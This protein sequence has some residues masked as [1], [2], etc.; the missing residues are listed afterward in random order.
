MSKGAFAEA[1][2][3]AVLQ[4]IQGLQQFLIKYPPFDQ[5]EPTHLVYLIE[6]CQLH[7]YAAGDCIA[8]PADG[9]IEH[10]YIIKQGHVIGQRPA[11][12]GEGLETHLE[13]AVGECFPMA[14]MIGE[15]A[16]RTEYIADE[17][18][19]CLRFN[20]E[21]FTRLLAESDPF[22]D[23][24]MRG[25]S[26]LLQM[27]NQQVQLKAAET[28]GAQYSLDTRLGE[29]CGRSPVTCRSGI[30][31]REAVCTM[32]EHMIGGL[33]MVD[34]AFSPMGLFALRDLRR[35]IADGSGQL[36]TPLEELMHREPF[37]LP[38]TATAFDAA[39]AMTQRHIHHVLV[40]EDDKLTGVI[41]ERD[42]F[43]LQRVDLVHLARSI[44][45][46]RSIGELAALRK[47][48]SHLVDNMLAHGA[49]PAQLTHIISL[50]NDH[51]VCRVIELIIEQDGDPGVPFTWLVFG[52]EGRREQTL[53]TDQDN[54]ILFEAGSQTRPT[55]FARSC[56]PWPGAS[57]RHWTSAA[58]P[59]ARAT[60]WPATRSCACHARNGCA[61]SAA[62]SSRRP[63]TTC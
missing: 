26:S 18:T 46:A 2:R 37:C 52:S 17:D 20:R 44:S 21:A 35:V 24:A 33:V 40:V 7:F 50:L 32:Q 59:C 8:K 61:A 15:R 36:D 53:H 60:S 49:S 23:F 47:D 12:S 29:L 13:V 63:R 54:G 41:S 9:R 11:L 48:I 14:A 57:T 42:L 62:S 1:G 22:R 51:T 38:P 27:V 56:Y 4:N 43:S 34:E 3:T 45:S 25:V 19:F 5:M 58:S 39:M 10:L 31:L 28:L 16:T 55:R 6:Q 30:S